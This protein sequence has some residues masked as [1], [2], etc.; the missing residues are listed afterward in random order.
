MADSTTRAA[1]DNPLT[2]A[3]A[4][5]S[6]GYRQQQSL[7]QHNHEY[8]RHKQRPGDSL[9]ATGHISTPPA[10]AGSA[11]TSPRELQT[12]SK[13]GVAGVKRGAEDGEVGESSLDSR[14]ES[15]ENG[16]PARKKQKRNKPTLSCAECVERKTKVCTPSPLRYS[17]F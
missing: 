5:Q 9:N 17:Y 13:V 12:S 7:H 15:Q 2:N 11:T 3:P 8:D 6:R 4:R 16:T 1:A 10:Q 14:S